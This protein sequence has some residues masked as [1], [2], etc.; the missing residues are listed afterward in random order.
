MGAS[1]SLD[2]PPAACMQLYLSLAICG[3]LGAIPLGV[4][5]GC[6]CLGL[7]LPCELSLCWYGWQGAQRVPLPGCDLGVL[8]DTEAPRGLG[9]TVW[10]LADGACSGSWSELPGWSGR[11][12]PLLARGKASLGPHFWSA[13]LEPV[14]A[15]QNKTGKYVPPSLRDGASRRGESM[16]P[17]RRGE[18]HWGARLAGG[19]LSAPCNYPCIVVVGVGWGFSLIVASPHPHSR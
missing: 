12:V 18:G 16:Q 2:G 10:G 5:L 15:A 11:S 3:A 7:H 8:V 9:V 14:Q 4:T 13:E 19:R 1:V 6:G 17:N